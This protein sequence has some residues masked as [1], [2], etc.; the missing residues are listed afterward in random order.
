RKLAD[1]VDDLKRVVFQQ[2]LGSSYEKMERF[3]QLALDLGKLTGKG[4]A[5]AIQRAATLCKADLVTGMVGEFPE[6]QGI[7]GRE[8]ARKQGEP[9]A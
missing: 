2:Q 4:D 9:E 8:Y 1:R 6:L 7:V 3:R 5:A